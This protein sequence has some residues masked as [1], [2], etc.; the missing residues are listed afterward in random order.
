MKSVLPEWYPHDGGTVSEILKT[1]TIAFDTNA[2]L[3]LYRVN[4]QERDDILD[5]ISRVKDRLF[6]PY[7]VA[8][9][10]QR[11]RL[12][13]VHDTASAYD[14]ILGKIT[15][16]QDVLNGIR[17][18]KLKK[19]VQSVF[20]DATKVLKD[21]LAE[22]RKEHAL[23][24]EEAR[25]DDPV[26]K[27]LDGLLGSGSIGSAPSNDE[28]KQRRAIATQRIKDGI[29]PG[30]A[31]A[32]DKPDPTGDYLI[33]HELLHHVGQSDRPLLFVTND[34]RKGDWYR[35]P[36]GGQPLGPLPALVAEMR[37]ASPSHAYHQVPLSTLLRLANEHLGA[38]VERSTIKTV[39]SIEPKSA[40][41]FNL[42]EILSQDLVDRQNKNSARLLA[43]LLDSDV[44]RDAV[45]TRRRDLD[46]L[47]QIWTQI[48]TPEVRAMIR[49][50]GREPTSTQDKSA[51]P[52]E[53]D[54]TPIL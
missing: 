29:P 26:L 5:V 16:P 45:A 11:N 42:G 20:A 30:F 37:I 40:I 14:K 54:G 49:D 21:G 41:E 50:A 32:K 18:S 53:D 1:G 35:E 2:L 24:L 33:W 27:A 52:D 43:S 23:S 17:D 19:Q 48:G 9:E 8:L 47:A 28:L 12:K 10:F 51:T 38:S 31:D 36:V 4:R 25:K 34:E 46:N 39:E 22:L 13:V 7:Q 15:L 44:L 6:I 3:Q